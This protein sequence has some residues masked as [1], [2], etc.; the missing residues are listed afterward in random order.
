MAL[1]ANVQSRGRLRGVVT[2]VDAMLAQ[3]DP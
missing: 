2:R 3:D 1:G